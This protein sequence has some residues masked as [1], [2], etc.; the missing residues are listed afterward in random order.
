M[1]KT[2]SWLRQ[3]FALKELELNYYLEKIV[4]LMIVV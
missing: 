3:G 4:W 2:L 1:I